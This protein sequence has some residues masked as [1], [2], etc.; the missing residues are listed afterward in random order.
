LL[1]QEY[2]FEI[3]VK[4][5]KLNAG[6]DHLSRLETGEELAILDKN[7]PN[8]QLFLVSTVDNYFE[9]IGKFLSIGVAPLEYTMA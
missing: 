6:P 8:V 4:P 7:L 2:D 9:H 1:F 3:V 5:R